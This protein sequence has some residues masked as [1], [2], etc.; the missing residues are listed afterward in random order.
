MNAASGLPATTKQQQD[1][2]V[3]IAAHHAPSF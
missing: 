2:I 1:T 3:S